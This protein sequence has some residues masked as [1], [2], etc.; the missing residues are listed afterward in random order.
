M[1]V[2]LFILL[3]ISF[4]AEWNG[5]YSSDPSAPVISL[6]DISDSSTTIKISLDGYYSNDINKR[7]KRFDIECKKL[8]LLKI[9]F[10]LHL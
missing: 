8:N 4:A 9:M 6:E 3:S 10:L 2:A 1:I 5:V 7:I